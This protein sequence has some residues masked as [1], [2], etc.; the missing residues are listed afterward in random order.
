MSDTVVN[1]HLRPQAHAGIVGGDH[2]EQCFRVAP[3]QGT[4]WTVR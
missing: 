3:S 2:L 1:P 4:G